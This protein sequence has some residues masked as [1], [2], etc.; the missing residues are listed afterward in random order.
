MIFS[1]LSKTSLVIIATSVVLLL[2]D[3]AESHSWA[4]CVDWRFKDPK[5]VSFDEKDGSCFGYARRYRL[6]DVFPLGKKVKFG[7]LDRFSPSRHY[8]QSHSNPDSA[9]PCSFQGSVDE[10]EKMGSPIESAYTTYKSGSDKKKF[11]PMSLKRAGDKL[12]MRWPAKTHAVDGDM[13]NVFFAISGLNPKKDPT[14][15]EFLN[16]GTSANYNGKT[17]IIAELPYCDK[18]GGEKDTYPCGGCVDLP[19]NLQN[20]FYV[21]QWRWRLNKN[22]WYTSCA[23]IKINNTK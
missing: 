18:K 1:T 14:Q 13:S 5:K 3:T 20:G 19:K 22:E 15:K 17:Q 7:G 10:N 9:P 2:S 6:G 23:D 21:M 11:G 4:D 12:C 8:E 16:K